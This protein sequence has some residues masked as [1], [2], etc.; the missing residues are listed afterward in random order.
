VSCVVRSFDANLRGQLLSCHRARSDTMPRRVITYAIRQSTDEDAFDPLLPSATA[1]QHRLS[2]VK[3][4][5]QS[6]KGT[7]PQLSLQAIRKAALADVVRQAES[8]EGTGKM[9]GKVGI[10][11]GVGPLTGIGVRSSLSVTPV[12]D[13]RPLRLD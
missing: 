1:S 4:N 2:A 9:K 11:T 13:G 12:A 10:M 8:K 5:R 7:E 3:A 6:G